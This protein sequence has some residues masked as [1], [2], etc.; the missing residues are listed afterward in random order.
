MSEALL[1]AST[2]ELTQEKLT[3]ANYPAA[4]QI[5]AK[6]R[7]FDK[8]DYDETP[9]LKETVAKLKALEGDIN[10]CQLAAAND[11]AELESIQAKVSDEYYYIPPEYIV[12][13]PEEIARSITDSVKVKLIKLGYSQDWALPEFSRSLIL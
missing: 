10:R 2:A 8:A 1:W 6:T 7:S 11:A 3:F 13:T 5:L 4:L 9:E 12:S